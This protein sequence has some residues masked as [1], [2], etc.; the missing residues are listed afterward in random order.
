MADNENILVIQPSRGWRHINLREI[1]RYRELLY[2]FT[3]RDVKV[4]YKQTIIGIL[5]AVLQPLITMLVFTIF[6]GKLAKVPSEG[7]PYPIFVYTGLL[8]WTYFAQS[9]ARSSGS[10]VAN[11]G[12]IKK[13]YFPRLITP[14]AASMS[15]LVDF[16]ISFI[17]LLFLMGYYKFPLTKGIVMF[18]LLLFLTFLC[19]SG[20]SFWLSALNALYRDIRII[21]PFCIQ[22]G[23]FLTPVIYPVSILP[24][25][26]SWILYLNPMTGIIESYRAAILGY[27]AIPVFGLS[28]SIAI[29][30]FFFIAGAFFFR[31]VEKTFADVV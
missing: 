22:L 18:P 1:W 28:L 4:R 13:V 27:K 16:M 21:V 2:F 6:F 30:A 8:P 3:W 26:Y 23:M 11:S 24:E 7:I 5:W 25:K 10:I 31:R 17:I 20:I 15:A 9:L 19:S 14:I 12:M 29:T